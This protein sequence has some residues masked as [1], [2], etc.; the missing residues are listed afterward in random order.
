MSD[1]RFKMLVIVAVV[2]YALAPDLVPGPV[3]D[4]I[5]MI[6]GYLVSSKK[7][8]MENNIIDVEDI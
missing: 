6:L 4:I 5:V 2:V 8:T 3:D 1:K 7:D